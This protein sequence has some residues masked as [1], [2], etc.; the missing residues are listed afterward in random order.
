MGFIFTQWFLDNFSGQKL[1]KCDRTESCYGIKEMYNQVIV[2]ALKV[3]HDT[4]KP[5][6]SHAEWDHHIGGVHEKGRIKETG[7]DMPMEMLSVK[8]A[9]I[10]GKNQIMTSYKPCLG[11]GWWGP[12]WTNQFGKPPKKEAQSLSRF[13][14]PGQHCVPAHQTFGTDVWGYYQCQNWH[15]TQHGEHHTN[16]HCFQWIFK[17]PLVNHTTPRPPWNGATISWGFFLYYQLLATDRKI[18]D[19]YLSWLLLF[20]DLCHPA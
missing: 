6:V 7:R 18:M 15:F 16:C 9:V 14:S 2:I 20:W 1:S 19:G 4:I 12:R 8:I 17:V 11:C 13:Q 10:L 3:N 5:S